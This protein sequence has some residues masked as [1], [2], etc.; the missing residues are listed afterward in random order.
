MSTSWRLASDA[1]AAV[2][3][4]EEVMTWAGDTFNSLY[5]DGRLEIILISVFLMIIGFSF[6]RRKKGHTPCNS[7]ADS[8]SDRDE[9]TAVSDTDDDGGEAESLMNMVLQRN[10]ELAEEVAQLKAGSSSG[11]S[12]GS[13]NV[14]GD[15]FVVDNQM[16]LGVDKLLSRLAAQ[17]NSVELDAART[18]SALAVKGTVAAQNVHSVSGSA[19]AAVA[20]VVDEITKETADPRAAFLEHLQQYEEMPSWAAH[21]GR[22]R[23]A[24]KVLGHLYKGGRSAKQEIELYV[25][26]KELTNC[27]AASELLLMAVLLD[28]MIASKGFDLINSDAIEIICRRVYGLFRAFDN[29]H[30]LS[31]WKAPKGAGGKWRTK[32]Q[33]DLA[34]QYDVLALDSGELRID[35]ADDEVRRRMERAALF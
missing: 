2:E 21:T 5:E 26:K 28:R 13:S 6:L 18:G 11:S 12:G 35:A 30:R 25:S 9:G 29:V 15:V 20:G 3:G 19:P 10:K 27:H 4:A 16:S 8:D 24:P 1:A 7:E 17:E 33:W 31:D 34:D 23:V 14:E 22:A 32:V